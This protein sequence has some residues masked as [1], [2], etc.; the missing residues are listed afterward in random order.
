MKT[1]TPVVTAL[2]AFLVL[3]PAQ[4]ASSFTNGNFETGNL[5]GWTPSSSYSGVAGGSPPTVTVVTAGWAPL[6]NNMLSRLYSGT[7]SCE[8]YSG[9]GDPGHNTWARISQT[10]V[11]GAGNSILTFYYA[12]VLDGSHAAVPSDD[13]YMTVQ[14]YDNTLGFYIVSNTY[15]YG[16][17]PAPLVDDGVFST[18]HLPWTLIN[19]NLGAYVGHTI[20]VSFTAYDCNFQGHASRAYVDGFEFVSPTPTFSVTPTFSYSPTQSATLTITRTFSYSPTAT[21]SPTITPTYSHSPTYTMTPTHSPTR[22]ATPSRTATL[23]RTPT[24]TATPSLTSTR[25]S[26]PTPTR[27]ATRTPTATRTATASATYT[28]SFTVTPT[29]S[30]SPTITLTYTVTPTFTITRTFT[31]TKTPVDQPALVKVRGIYPNPF[32]DQAAVWFTLT[33]DAKMTLGIYNV[34]GELVDTISQQGYAGSN[35]IPWKGEN[36]SGGR[37]ASGVYILRLEG[38]TS[39]G[40]ANVAWNQ[41]VVAR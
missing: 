37:V 24:P 35:I 18:K 11:I 2:F 1:P 12:A 30:H 34:A 38:M 8:L 13:A 3:F 15:A 5:F 10:D 25:S 22:T 41:A 27:T 26:S 23:T 20:T 14:V 16:A 32:R 7:Y 21:P 36:S 9:Y 28:P 31:I 39:Y 17:S 6:T 19:L 33:E 4:K 29:F 40:L